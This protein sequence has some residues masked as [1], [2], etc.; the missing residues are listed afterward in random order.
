MHTFPF[1]FTLQSASPWWRISCSIWLS[2]C[3][4][5]LHNTS[6]LVLNFHLYEILLALRVLLSSREFVY[7]SYK[8]I[9]FLFCGYKII[10]YFCGVIKNKTYIPTVLELFGLKFI[11]FTFEHQ[12]PHVHVRSVNG[13]AK[14]IIEEEAKLVKS[15]LKPKELKLSEYILEENLEHIRNEWKRIHGE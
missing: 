5:T 2:R 14:F 13:E 6:E 11:I 9:S 12:P 10:S 15:T 1:L 4:C 3:W 8:F 7:K